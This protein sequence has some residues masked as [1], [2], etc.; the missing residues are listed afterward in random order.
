M[1]GIHA[2]ILFEEALQH[3]DAVIIGEGELLWKDCLNDVKLNKLKRIYK[4]PDNFFID[5]RISPPPSYHLLKKNYQT[6]GNDFFN[7]IP[8]QVTRGC[9][10]NCSFCIVSKLYGKNI[11]IKN[12]D[13][14][15]FEINTIKNNFNDLLI[16]FVDDNLFACKKFANEL[17]KQIKPLKVR[18]FAQSD[19]SIAYDNELLESAYSAGCV[20]MLIGFESLNPNNLKTINPNHWKMKQLEKYSQAVQ[21]IQKNGIIVYAAFIVGFDYDNINV[22]QEIKDFIIANNCPGQFTVLTPLPGTEIFNLLKKENRLF[23]PTYWDQCNF[24]DITFKPKQMTKNEIE[25]GLIWLYD[26]VFSSEVIEKRYSY[27]KNIYKLLSQR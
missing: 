14:I 27:M 13:Q 21:L 12:I 17:L 6:K 23:S 10:H 26:E 20:M 1:G 9:P 19:I 22:F 18:W 7:M 2:S 25:N 24:F 15:V 11:R 4:N 16:G 5:L 8:I 3:V